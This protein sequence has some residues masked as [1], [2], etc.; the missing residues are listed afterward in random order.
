MRARAC[1]LGRCNAARC[2]D[3]ADPAEGV[4]Q[5]AGALRRAPRGERRPARCAPGVLL[6]SNDSQ[7]TAVSAARPVASALPAPRAVMR[8]APL[9]LSPRLAASRAVSLRR[10]TRPLPRAAA[11]R[12]T[13]AALPAD[14]NSVSLGEL[15]S[16]LHAF[17]E[18]RDWAQFHTPRNL[19]LALTGEVGELAECFQWRSDAECGAGLPG[20]SDNDRTHLGEEL[21]DCACRRTQRADSRTMSARNGSARR[22]LSASR[23]VLTQPLSVT[24]AH[25]CRLAVC[26]ATRGPVRR[27]PGRSRAGKAREERGEVP[28]RA[29]VRFA[30]SLHQHCTA[31]SDASLDNSKG[32]A[33]KYD[34]LPPAAGADGSSDAAGKHA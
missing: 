19:A 28:R 34:A 10:R 26:G 20:W 27:R 9:A 3:G 18:A 4:R 24:N 12:S 22:T 15:R 17:A 5:F 31:R 11:A 1:S 23:C 30:R 6:V 13:M 16:R 32:S 29:L 21:S 25:P 2:G 8:N 14:S 7:S 33:A